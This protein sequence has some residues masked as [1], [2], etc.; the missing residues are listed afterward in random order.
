[1]YVLKLSL[2]KILSKMLFWEKVLL[3]FHMNGS[4]QAKVS[5]CNM[6]FAGLRTEVLLA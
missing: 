6:E 2:S 1:M 3:N 4:V 5:G